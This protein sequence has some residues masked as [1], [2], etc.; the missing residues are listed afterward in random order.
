M[1]INIGAALGAAVN[2]GISTYERLGEEQLRAMQREQLRKEIAE[3]EALDQAWR[4]SQARVG[5][6]DDYTQALKTVS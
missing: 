3:K 1:A 6:T 4:Q 5:Q 2:T